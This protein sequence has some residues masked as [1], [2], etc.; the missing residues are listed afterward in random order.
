MNA[1]RPDKEI[2]EEVSGTID[3]VTFHDDESGFRDNKL[4]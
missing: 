1:T 3:R 4:F 2:A